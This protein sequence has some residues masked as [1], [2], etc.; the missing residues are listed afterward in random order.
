MLLLPIHGAHLFEEQSIIAA[1]RMLKAASDARRATSI[2][3]R[4]RHILRRRYICDEDG[5]DY[6]SYYESRPLKRHI[7]RNVSAAAF[8]FKHAVILPRVATDKC[9]SRQLYFSTR[10]ACFATRMKCPRV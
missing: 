1:F 7:R 3:A 5:D 8:L 4:N 10:V 9:P 6:C 2:Y